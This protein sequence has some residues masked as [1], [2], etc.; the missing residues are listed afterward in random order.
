MKD[1]VSFGLVDELTSS[2]CP[3]GDARLAWTKLESK[4]E[5]QTSAS[6]VKLMNQFTS[7]RLKKLAQD[8]DVWISELELI[9]TRLSKMG[10]TLDDM[11]MMMHVLNNLP[12]AYDNLVDG[13]EDKLGAKNDPLT[14]EGLRE[15]LSEKYEKIRSRR[16]FRDDNSDS[17]EE[18]RERYSQVESLKD[19]A[20]T[21]ENSAIKQLNAERR[22]VITEKIPRTTK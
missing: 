20:T 17:E 15:K 22:R 10:T 2:T 1:D 11:Y 6:R 18:E 12:S 7:N 14:L 19:V 16:K 9:R 5:S 8:P 3:E 4:F 21:A 13:L